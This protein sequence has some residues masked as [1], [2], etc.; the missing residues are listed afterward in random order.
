MM[1][2]IKTNFYRRSW[3]HHHVTSSFFIRPTIGRPRRRLAA[4]SS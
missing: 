4:R 1:V 2:I 3:C